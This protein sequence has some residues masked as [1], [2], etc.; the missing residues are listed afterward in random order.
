[1]QCWVP[2]SAPG[3]SY[4]A[5]PAALVLPVPSSLPVYRAP[6]VLPV[7]PWN[8]FFALKKTQLCDSCTVS[9]LSVPS[10]SSGFAPRSLRRLNCSSRRLQCRRRSPRRISFSE[11][12]RRALTSTRRS[13]M[14]LKSRST[15]NPRPRRTTRGPWVYGM[16]RFTAFCP[17]A[18]SEKLTRETD[19]HRTTLALTRTT[20]KH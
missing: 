5:W 20:W 17:C 13:S 8:A 3:V 6:V 2:C 10:P 14:A 11:L 9:L 12:G 18:P 1:M 15:S 19:T 16:G 7:V 4:K